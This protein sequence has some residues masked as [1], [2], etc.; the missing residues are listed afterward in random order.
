MWHHHYQGYSNND[1]WVRR[2]EDE[3]RVSDGDRG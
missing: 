3:G 1:H 2:R